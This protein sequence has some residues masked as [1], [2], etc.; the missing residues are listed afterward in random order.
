MIAESKESTSGSG[1]GG[2]GRKRCT[3]KGW[4]VSAIEIVGVVEGAEPKLKTRAGTHEGITGVGVEV[5]K[6]EVGVQVVVVDIAFVGVPGRAVK[7]GE[8]K[9]PNMFA[10]FSSFPFPSLDTDFPNIFDGC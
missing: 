4:K 1:G 9:F 2:G 6:I 10:A 8:S 3:S 5:E 7:A